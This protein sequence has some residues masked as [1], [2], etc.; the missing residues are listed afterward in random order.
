MSADLELYYNGIGSMAWAIY[1][2]LIIQIVVGAAL[3][4]A[5]ILI[6]VVGHRKYTRRRK[7]EL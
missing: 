5:G 7:G 2:P 6:L 4:V 3:A 1:L